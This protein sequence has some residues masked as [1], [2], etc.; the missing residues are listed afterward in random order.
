VVII[1]FCLSTSSLI[2]SAK[3]TVKRTGDLRC[4]Y[5]WC[6]IDF[7]FTRLSCKL[8]DS[9]AFLV[10]EGRPHCEDGCGTFVVAVLLVLAGDGCGSVLSLVCLHHQQFY[11]FCK[12][13]NTKTGSGFEVLFMYGASLIFFSGGPLVSSWTMLLFPI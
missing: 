5:V 4:F 1:P 3:S 11:I 7:H 6:L 13:N 10:E 9:V 12:E 2:T 8:G